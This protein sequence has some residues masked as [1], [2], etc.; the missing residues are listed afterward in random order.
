MAKQKSGLGRGLNALFDDSSLNPTQSNPINTSVSSSLQKEA[1]TDVSRET[2]KTV[3][4]NTSSS[5]V[6]SDI[7]ISEDALENAKVVSR[8]ARPKTATQESA[9]QERKSK[10]F[11]QRKE[12]L[13]H[14]LQT[15]VC[16]GLKHRYRLQ[17][18][19]Q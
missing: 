10:S 11:F 19:V 17:A 9:R 6:S 18:I 13:L 1:N 16:R 5:K 4:P 7:Y 2:S 8:E 15:A 12:S 3:S 14:K